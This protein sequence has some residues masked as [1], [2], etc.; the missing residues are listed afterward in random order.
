MKGSLFVLKLKFKSLTLYF[1]RA[2]DSINKLTSEKHMVM[3]CLLLRK[4]A[5]QTSKS[6]KGPFTVHE[7][8]IDFIW[9]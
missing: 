1:H 5:G 6:R 7:S 3:V 9:E 8:E 4:L 2:S